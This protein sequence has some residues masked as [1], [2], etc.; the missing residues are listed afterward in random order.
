MGDGGGDAWL[1]R[2]EGEPGPLYMRLLAALERAIG[3]GELQPGD[4]LPSQRAAAQRLGVDFT[5]VTRAYALARA[6]G[7][8]CTVCYTCPGQ[9][10]PGGLWLSEP[11]FQRQGVHS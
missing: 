7:L 3:E 9:V 2:F 8:C 1:R 10:A 4:Q 6:R 11:A 5:T